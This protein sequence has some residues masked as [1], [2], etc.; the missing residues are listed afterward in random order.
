MEPDGSSNGDERVPSTAAGGVG[1]R[2]C[3]GVG[4]PPA[5]PATWGRRNRRPQ[6]SGGAGDRQ[7]Q[8]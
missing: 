8:M 5:D 7:R 3:S 1:H 2:T 4:V 6:D